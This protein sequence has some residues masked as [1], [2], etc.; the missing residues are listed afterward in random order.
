M[1]YR[2][3]ID[4]LRAIAVVSVILFHAGFP[5]IKGGFLGVD[6][7]F[8]IS[9][10]LITSIVMRELD[11]GRFSFLNFYERRIKR[12]LPALYLVMMVSFIIAW[13]VLLPDQM[14]GFSRSLIAASLMVS[15]IFFFR[16]TGYFDRDT[17]LKPLIHTWSL[18]IEEQFYLIYPA[19]LIAI[20]KFSRHKLSIWLFALLCISFFHAEMMWRIDQN[21]NFYLIFSRGWELMAGAWI[22]VITLHK[23]IYSKNHRNILGLL[24]LIVVLLSLFMMDRSMPIPSKYTLIPIFGTM[25]VLA[26][27]DNSSFSGRVL[28]NKL[29]VGIGLISYSLYLWHQP[30]LAFFKVEYG[31]NIS[32]QMVGI[33]I[34]L[35]FVLSVLSYKFVELPC[36]KAKNISTRNIFFI[37]ILGAV[38]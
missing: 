3:Q 30:I 12:I 11:N 18:G 22:A 15:N 6:I 21:K 38:F 7:F 1:Q 17:E 16:Q 14:K 32:W 36:R 23:E 19:I 25:L 10:F 20:F 37:A 8:V 35:T 5:L 33:C 13:F 29:L 26:F 28:S 9:G 34:V 31:E 2:P 27:S 4:G 24:G